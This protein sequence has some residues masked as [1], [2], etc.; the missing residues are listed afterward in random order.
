MLELDIDQISRSLANAFHN[1]VN[2]NNDIQKLQVYHNLLLN[3][4]FEYNLDSNGQK[5]TLE[6][7]YLTS[8]NID[9]ALNS[10]F[11]RTNLTRKKLISLLNMWSDG[12]RQCFK[13]RDDVHL[14]YMLQR[15]LLETIIVREQQGSSWIKN[16]E[17]TY[18]FF[19]S[20]LR[21]MRFEEDLMELL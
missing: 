1:D 4:I 17:I 2:Q 15:D 9:E 21:F 16:Y 8:S 5:S 13:K 6:K 20:V 12:I 18:A 14:I 10:Y 3:I 19:A 7:V 11:E